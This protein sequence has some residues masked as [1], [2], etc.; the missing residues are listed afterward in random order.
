MWF[1]IRGGR[2]LGLPNRLRGFGLIGGGSVS[3]GEYSGLGLQGAL[4]E[5]RSFSC[6]RTWIELDLG[7][8]C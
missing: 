5:L 7:D 3:S 2:G 1:L 6:F 8:A 4:A